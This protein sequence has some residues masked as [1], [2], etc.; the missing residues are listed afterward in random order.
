MNLNHD[1]AEATVCTRLHVAV[2]D[3]FTVFPHDLQI[4]HDLY[5]AAP[6]ETLKSKVRQQ[7]PPSEGDS[8]IGWKNPACMPHRLPTDRVRVGWGITPLLHLEKVHER[9]PFC[10]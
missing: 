3:Y 5:A 4:E 9:S 2:R 6:L 7:E 8:L 10:L 1:F